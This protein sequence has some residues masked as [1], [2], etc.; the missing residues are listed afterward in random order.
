MRQE[1][2]YPV[3]APAPVQAPA[4]PSKN[5][6]ER[7]AALQ[8]Q[9]A[10]GE[11]QDTQTDRQIKALAGVAPSSAE[12]SRIPRQLTTQARRLLSNLKL[13]IEGAGGTLKDIVQVL[14]Y[15]TDGSE[16]P[17]MT[18]AAM[19]SS[20]MSLPEFASPV[21]MRAVSRMPAIAVSSAQST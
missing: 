9:A 10:A 4:A 13:Q 5:P 1:R 6:A 12:N 15:V 8:K 16:T 11:R 18:Q 7:L 21:S 14:I 3:P 20:G 2:E 17:A 19:V